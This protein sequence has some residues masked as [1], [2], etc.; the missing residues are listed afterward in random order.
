MELEIRQQPPT[1]S[2]STRCRECSGCKQ[3]AMFRAVGFLIIL[4]GLSKLFN[5]FAAFDVALVEVFRAV[6]L[7]AQQT[8]ASIER[9]R[10][11]D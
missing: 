8:Q 10:E 1:I 3:I 5:S 7:S 9:L 4:W 6:E 2:W 11:E